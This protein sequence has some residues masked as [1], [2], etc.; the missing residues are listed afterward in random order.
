[1]NNYGRFLSSWVSGEAKAKENRSNV[2]L[3]SPKWESSKCILSFLSLLFVIVKRINFH[4][5]TRMYDDVLP[6]EIL[7]N[8]SA[9]S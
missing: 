4:I 9:Q 1:M 6:F 2:S 8:I 7:A 5:Y 3:S